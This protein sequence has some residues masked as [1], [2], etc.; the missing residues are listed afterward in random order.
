MRLK[1]T[2]LL[3]H[4][5]STYYKMDPI[6]QTLIYSTLDATIT[7]MPASYLTLDVLTTQ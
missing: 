6:E 3:N 2:D 5:Y 7:Q 1:T 4:T